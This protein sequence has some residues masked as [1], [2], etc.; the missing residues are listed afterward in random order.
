M[1]QGPLY[2]YFLE[3]NKSV[4]V[5]SPWNVPQAEALF[6]GCGLQIVTGSR[7]LGGFVGTDTKQA[8]WLGE[9]IS[10]WRDSVA[11][12]AGVACRHPQIS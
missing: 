6:M 5:V 8:H 7:Y 12:L 2:S 1:V 9:N 11:T 4:L 3:P 10:V